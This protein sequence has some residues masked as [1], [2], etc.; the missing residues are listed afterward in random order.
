[1]PHHPKT[2]PM[3]PSTPKSNSKT[4]DLEIIGTNKAP[5]QDAPSSPTVTKYAHEDDQDD[6]DDFAA[7]DV[8]VIKLT[9]IELLHQA[10]EFRDPKFY[11]Q[12]LTLDAEKRK[13]QERADQLK[14]RLDMELRI[15]ERKLASRY[16]G[17]TDVPWR[18]PM[19][20]SLNDMW[21]ALRSLN[22][23]EYALQDP[24]ISSEF[25]ENLRNMMVR[26]DL[27]KMRNQWGPDYP[28]PDYFHEYPAV[29]ANYKYKDLEG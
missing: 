7:S 26:D 14:H 12:A 2:D 28:I 22:N 8:E 18:L 11:Y 20:C 1:M 17:W 13:L 10:T 9:P 4:V 6:Q 25:F 27:N 23:H 16:Y 29:N 21:G 3:H 15:K 5:Y 24:N 19:Q